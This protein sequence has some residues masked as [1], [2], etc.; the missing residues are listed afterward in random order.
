MHERRDERDENGRDEQH[1]QL[2]AACSVLAALALARSRAGTRLD[3]RGFGR[4]A[5]GR[6][7]SV[8]SMLFS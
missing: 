7:M 6:T 1:E 5:Q 2:T 8:I 4:A 3:M